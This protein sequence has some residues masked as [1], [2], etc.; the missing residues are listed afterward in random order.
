[1]GEEGFAECRKWRG[2]RCNAKKKGLYVWC[3]GMNEESA[4]GWGQQVQYP[5]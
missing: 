2:T 4:G 5:C 3:A 1:M